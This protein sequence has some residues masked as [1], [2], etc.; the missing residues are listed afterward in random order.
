MDTKKMYINGAWVEG[1]EGKTFKSVNPATGEVNA[2]ICQSGLED[3]SS[4]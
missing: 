1:S 3:K 4:Y 2:E